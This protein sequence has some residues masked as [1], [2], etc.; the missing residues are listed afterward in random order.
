MEREQRI[1]RMPLRKKLL[2]SAGAAVLAFSFSSGVGS[3]DSA[4]GKAPYEWTPYEGPLTTLVVP[5]TA[6][7]AGTDRN[8]RDERIQQ[9]RD[10]SP[11]ERLTVVF[12][13]PSVTPSSETSLSPDEQKIQD[14]Q[15]ETAGYVQIAQESGKVSDKWINDLK[16]YGPI[17]IEAAEKFGI[18][19]KMLWVT[20]EIESGASAKDSKAFD[21]STYPYVGGMQRNQKTWSD[22]FIKEAF[23]SLEYLSSIP[24]NHHGDAQEIAGAAAMMGPNMKQ[25]SE[26]GEKRAIFNTFSLF[27]GSEVSAQERLDI[28][29]M[30]D[31][32]FLLPNSKIPSNFV[33]EK[34]VQ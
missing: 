30:I 21:G 34:T 4:D 13:S 32:V 9:N 24:T 17:Y 2:L 26:L 10:N 18:D 25:Y 23:S 28:W 14:L 6:S 31:N 22:E 7:E 8:T 1:K 19:W 20:H 16:M 27:S 15:N 5:S 33:S 29:I 11:G 12:P 3:S